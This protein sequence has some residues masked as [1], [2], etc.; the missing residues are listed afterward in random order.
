MKKCSKCEEIIDISNFYKSKR[1]KDGLR[2]NCKFCE[3]KYRNSKKQY[4]KDYFKEYYENNK[5]AISEKSKNYYND[6]KDKRLKY[7]SNYYE[8]NREN[9]IKYQKKYQNNNKDKRNKYLK[10]RRDNDP[11]YK[12]EV[13]IRNLIN[14]SFYNNGFNK[15]NRTHSILGCSFKDLKNH[16]ESMFEEWMSWDNRGLYNGDYN[17]GWDIDHIIPISSAT[18]KEDLIKLNHYTNLQPLCSKV[19]RDDKRNIID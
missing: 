17:Y 13:N 10:E 14:N 18:T 16:L 3:K 2:S 8:N 19:N 5:E 1:N 4:L 7:Q 6:N 15:D 9:K 11:L 12:L